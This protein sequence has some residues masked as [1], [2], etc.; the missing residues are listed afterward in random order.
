MFGPK[1]TH[2]MY[3]KAIL[4]TSKLMFLI[5]VKIKKIKKTGLFCI[6]YMFC[7]ND[8]SNAKTKGSVVH[9]SDHTFLP[10]LIDKFETNLTNFHFI[11]C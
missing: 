6:F 7:K 8:M 1:Q 4:A 10:L 9:T 2:F 5:L 11:A 3:F